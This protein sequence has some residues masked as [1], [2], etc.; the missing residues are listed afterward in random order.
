MQHNKYGKN[1][2]EKNKNVSYELIAVTGQAHR[3]IFTYMCKV[4]NKTGKQ[5][6]NFKI[7]LIKICN[8]N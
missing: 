3:P 1:E 5:V 6:P 8:K 7:I 2:G 4:L